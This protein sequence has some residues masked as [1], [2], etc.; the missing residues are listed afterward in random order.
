MP[1]RI[2]SALIAIVISAA[3]LT[4]SCPISAANISDVPDSCAQ[5][6][7]RRGDLNGDGNLSSIDAVLI[8]R[9]L[10]GLSDADADIS[11]AD[12]NCDGSVSSLDAVL[13][14]RCLA[15]LGCR[16]YY[17]LNA[18]D[19]DSYPEYQTFING[20]YAYE[21][22]PPTRKGYV[23]RGWFVTPDSSSAFD[24]FNFDYPL[25]KEDNDYS[26]DIYA[27]WMKEDP[28]KTLSPEIDAELS[29]DLESKISEILGSETEIVRSDEFIP[30]KTYTGKAFYV[31]ADG[32]DGNDGL[33]PETAWKTLAKV[34]YETCF[35]ENKTVM[36]GD[37]IFFRRGDVFRPGSFEYTNSEGH[38]SRSYDD[39]FIG[40]DRI[41]LSAYGEGQKPVITCS[42]ESGADADKWELVYSDSSGKKIWKF[43]NMLRDVGCIRLGKVLAERVYEWYSDG[44]YYSCDPWAVTGPD[45]SVRLH[46]GLDPLEVSLSKDLTFI[47]RPLRTDVSTYS[48]SP[49]S[50]DYSGVGE[51]YLRCDEGNPGEVFDVVEFAEYNICGNLYICCDGIVLDNL[52][53]ADGGVSLIKSSEIF[54]D[55]P[56]LKFYRDAIIQNC[57]FS[58][59][60][61]SVHNYF[62]D[63]LER[64]VIGP[65]GDGIYNVV[66][67]ATITRNYFHDCFSSSYTFEFDPSSTATPISGYLKIT[68]NVA[69]RSGSFVF[70]NFMPMMQHLSSI[71]FS[72]NRVYY[73]GYYGA[74]ESALRSGPAYYDEFIIENNIFYETLNYEEL[75]DALLSMDIYNY[76]VF[77]LEPVIYRGNIYVQDSDKSVFKF[78]SNSDLFRTD[79]QAI[80]S[81]LREY[82]GDSTSK[83]YIIP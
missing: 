55:D 66:D 10:A 73:T 7:S 2:F 26:I 25:A 1:K 11:N 33:T 70:A 39:I 14:L 57:E 20:G 46:G 80:M 71:V 29:Y 30:G 81:K 64:P 63:E 53:F 18:D 27:Q 79:D 82:L 6:V 38:I 34:A 43:Y 9:Y 76:S 22:E 75:N 21:P 23:F 56:N 19:A 32:D 52:H 51:L 36:P 42:S 37:A 54:D 4:L 77:G 58:S 31:S 45:S 16:L 68:D 49:D 67:N 83:V 35:S 13:I 24:R 44:K 15:G 50:L 3:F 5:S 60:G 8:L 62:Y 12:V 41:T 48:V 59:C 74:Q 69:L 40:V 17:H 28:A 61:G 72:G 78:L 47:S 65:Q